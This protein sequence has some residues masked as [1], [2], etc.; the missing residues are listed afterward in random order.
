MSK[1]KGFTLIEL[2]IV[3]TIIAM[4][5]GVVISS[6]N[7]LRSTS[8]DAKRKAD[9]AQIKSALQNYYADLNYFPHNGTGGFKLNGAGASTSLTSS[10]GITSPAP[11]PA[12]PLKTYLPIVPSDQSYGYCYIPVRDSSSNNTDCDNTNT[13][14]A[15]KRCNYYYLSTTLD[16]PNPAMTLPSSSVGCTGQTPNY[17]ITP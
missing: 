4:M 16:N 12:P 2:M 14:G 17:Y 9:L 13:S 8:N 11:N 10:M 7:F 15:N 3:I 6:A 5:F 1:A